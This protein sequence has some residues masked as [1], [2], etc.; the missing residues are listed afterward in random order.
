[1]G[2]LPPAISDLHVQ[3]YDDDED[4]ITNEAPTVVID[5]SFEDLPYYRDE[6][7]DSEDPQPYNEATFSNIQAAMKSI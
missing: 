3:E 1:M 4:D 2:D 5:S 6:F 7:A